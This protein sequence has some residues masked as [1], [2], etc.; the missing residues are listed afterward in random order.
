MSRR[1][2]TVHVRVGSHAYHNDV[3]GIADI[4]SPFLI[5]DFS[6]CMSP[7]EHGHHGLPVERYPS[8]SSW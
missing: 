2:A 8:L 7:L 3:A 4:T 5:P 6:S 1:G